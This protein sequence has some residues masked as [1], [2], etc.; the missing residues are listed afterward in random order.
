[1]VTNYIL[2]KYNTY[3]LYIIY[4]IIIIYFYEMFWYILIFNKLLYSLTGTKKHNYRIRHVTQSLEGP[5]QS[6]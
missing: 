3:I 4:I 1:M 2:S 5:I 6:S